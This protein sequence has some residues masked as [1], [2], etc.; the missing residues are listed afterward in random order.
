MTTWTIPDPMRTSGREAG[1]GSLSFRTFR[2]P[3]MTWSLTGSLSILK[4]S[5]E[6]SPPRKRNPDEFYFPTREKGWFCSCRNS[7]LKL[8]NYISLQS[9]QSNKSCKI[10]NENISLASGQP[11]KLCTEIYEMSKFPGKQKFHLTPEFY[12]IWNF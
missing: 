11:V 4:R 3:S 10:K 1:S 12:V 2:S 7:S 5:S 8:L 6:D 9:L